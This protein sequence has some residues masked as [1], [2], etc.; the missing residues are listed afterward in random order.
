MRSTQNA[1]KCKSVYREHEVAGLSQEEPQI[2]KICRSIP[3]HRHTRMCINMGVFQ[4]SSTHSGALVLENVQE[5]FQLRVHGARNRQAWSQSARLRRKEEWPQY[6]ERTNWSR[7]PSMLH[8]PPTAERC[9]L[10]IGR[11]V[12]TT[13]PAQALT[14]NQTKHW[15]L[16]FPRPCRPLEWTT[17]FFRDR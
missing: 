17:P 16:H 2:C 8:L 11:A 9:A 3:T 12:Y 4:E 15:A 10:G 1:D 13:N 14:P 7:N 6:Q 5:Y